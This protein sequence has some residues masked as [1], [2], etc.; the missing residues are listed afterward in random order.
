MLSYFNYDLKYGAEAGEF[1]IMIGP[2]SA[3]VQTVRFELLD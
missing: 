1:D 3:N 2:N